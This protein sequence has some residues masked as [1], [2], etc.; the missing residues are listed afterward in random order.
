MDSPSAATHDMSTIT[1]TGSRTDVVCFTVVTV[2]SVSLMAV[3]SAIRVLWLP[4]AAQMK[5]HFGP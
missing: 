5:A 3:N 4:L 1:P 2:T